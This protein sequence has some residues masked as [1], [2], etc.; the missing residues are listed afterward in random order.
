[1]TERRKYGTKPK[2]PSFELR[3]WRRAQGQC[4]ECGKPTNPEG[5]FCEAH[6]D[7]AWAPRNPAERAAAGLC[8]T[9][10]SPDLYTYVRNGRW[11]AGR[12]CSGC[13]AHERERTAPSREVY[14]ARRRIKRRETKIRDAAHARTLQRHQARR[15]AYRAAGLC[16]RCGSPELHRYERMGR[17]LTGILCSRCT[18]IQHVYAAANKIKKAV[19][20]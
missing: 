16:V 13:A 7:C 20:T 8:V 12:Q 15:M 11:I 9:C 3:R 14:E 17:V 6:K 1:M 5:D 2:R 18:E 4:P 10:G 19:S